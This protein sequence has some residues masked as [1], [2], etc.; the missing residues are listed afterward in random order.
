[1]TIN[2]SSVQPIVADD[3]SIAHALE[4]A[5]IPTLMMSLIHLTGDA[6]ILDGDIRPTDVL[7]SPERQGNLTVD[8]QQTIRAR[9]LDALRAYRDAGSP[10][11]PALPIE[12]LNR[13]SSF[14]V[15]EPIPDEYLPMLYTDMRLNEDFTRPQPWTSESFEERREDYRVLII[16][17]GMSGVLAAIKLD[18]IGVPY[19]ILEKDQEFGG[20]WRDN[21]YPGCR[22]DSVNHFFSYS[23]ETNPDWSQHFSARDELFPYFKSVAEKYGIRKNVAFGT[24]VESMRWSEADSLW[25][26]SVRSGDGSVDTVIGNA[27]ITAVGQLS[28]PK[29]P[30]FPGAEKFKGPSCHTHGYDRSIP[31]DGRNIV[32]VGS[33]ASAVQ[34]VPELAKTAG[35]ISIFQRT[36]HWYWPTPEYQEYVPNGM[37]WLLGH[38]PGYSNWYRF[39]ICWSL[40]DGIRHWFE[41][42]PEWPNQQLSVN[43]INEG[44][45]LHFTNFITETVNNRP[46]LVSKLIPQ[47]PPFSDRILLNNGSYLR[48]LTQDNVDLVTS[49]VAEIDETG[50]IDG[51]GKHHD[52]DAI[53][54]ATGFNATKFLFPMTITGKDGIDINDYWD[55]EGRG[56]LGVT[57]PNFPNFFMIW[58]PGTAGGTGGSNIFFAECHM[59]YIRSAIQQM[60]DQGIDAIEPR[61]DVTE[62]YVERFRT[63]VAKMVWTSPAVKGWYKNDQG[64]VITN[65]PWRLVDYWTW[66]RAANMADFVTSKKERAARVDEL[67]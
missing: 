16:G 23:F 60:I 66:T 32:V 20:T 41:I 43:A 50:V 53:I 47:Y 59:R 21:T 39:M 8:Q 7:A 27:V 57:V 33:A 52:A 19:T 54:Y 34:M 38:V 28:R 17:A 36:P 12:T 1:M 49:G 18:E 51:D 65:L 24:E 37:K 5:N 25:Y 45:R 31:I 3:A 26:L 46:D 14:V 55:G 2:N 44:H 40:T 6:A 13:M 67:A 62:D 42:D 29:I 35:H 61:L 22:V 30:D 15:G 64:K 63:E 9:A 11:L 56:Y 10:A 4:E 48:A 58:G